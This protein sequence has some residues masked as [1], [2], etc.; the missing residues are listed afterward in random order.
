MNRYTFRA[1]CV[2]D[3]LAFLTALS[4]SHGVREFIAFQVGNFPDRECSVETR[5]T[6]LDAV[7]VADTC[8]DCHRIAETLTLVPQ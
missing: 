4:Q 5:A 6:L 1:E 7:R 8:D 3:V 2:A